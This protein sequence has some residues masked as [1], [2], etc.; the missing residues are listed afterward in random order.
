MPT[1]A[2]ADVL[3]GDWTGVLEYRDFANDRRVSLPTLIT[4]VAEGA[5]AHLTFTFDEGL[6]KT[7]YAAV[8][9]SSSVDGYSLNRPSV[10]R[11]PTT[12]ADGL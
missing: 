11:S 4:S 9:W 3:A 7:V 1:P 10:A 6:G 12:A 2:L 5:G 8:Q